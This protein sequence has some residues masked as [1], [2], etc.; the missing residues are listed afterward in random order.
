MKQGSLETT[1]AMMGPTSVA[2]HLKKSEEGTVILTILQL[3][4]EAK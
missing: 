1:W 4:K 3:K 2:N